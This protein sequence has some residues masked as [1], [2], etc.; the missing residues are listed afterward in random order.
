MPLV[1]SF[2]IEDC[3]KDEFLSWG[4]GIDWVDEN[5]YARRRKN[6]YSKARPSSRMSRKLRLEPIVFTLDLVPFINDLQ[7][8]MKPKLTL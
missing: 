1:L 7:S 3:I 4:T 6:P 5:K 2:F 8:A